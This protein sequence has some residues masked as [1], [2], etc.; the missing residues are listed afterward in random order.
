[1]ERSYGAELTFSANEAYHVENF[2]VL[3]ADTGKEIV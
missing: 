1:M 3:D 2:K